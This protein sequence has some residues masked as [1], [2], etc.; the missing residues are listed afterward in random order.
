MSAIVRLLIG[1]VLGVACAL[2]LSPAAA[3]IPLDWSGL[4]GGAMLGI[5]VLSVLLAIFA[6][7]I[8]RAAGRGFLF[9]GISFFALPISSFLLSGQAAS[10]VIAAADPA[11]QDAAVMGAGLVVVLLTGIGAFIGLFMGLIFTI[12]GLVMVLGGRRGVAGAR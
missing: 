10:H 11:D 2:V 7:S 9:L 4:A 3:A 1:L 12:L 8:R 6:P 5:I